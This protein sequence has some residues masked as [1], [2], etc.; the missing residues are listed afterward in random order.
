MASTAVLTVAAGGTVQAFLTFVAPLLNAIVT[1]KAAAAEVAGKEQTI[2]AF[3]AVG[4][5][6]KGALVALFA[7]LAVFGALRALATLLAVIA[8]IKLLNTALTAAGT[9]FGTVMA[10]ITLLTCFAPGAEARLASKAVFTVSVCF[11]QTSLAIAAVAS[12]IRRT[13][14]AHFADFTVFGTSGA[15]VAQR[16]EQIVAE[17]T[18][19]MATG[20]KLIILRTVAAGRAMIAVFKRAFIAHTTVI[21][22]IVI[23]AATAAIAQ[24]AEV[25][26]VKA[27][28]TAVSTVIAGVCRAVD[29]EIA[30]G[31][32]LDT[33][34]ASSAFLADIQIVAALVTFRTVGIFGAF[35]TYSAVF[36]QFIRVI[37]A[38]VATG[39]VVIIVTGSAAFTAAVRAFAA[40][41]VI[42]AAST[43][44]FALHIVIPRIGCGRMHR[45]R[46]DDHSQYDQDTPDPFLHR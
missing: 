14:L 16:A 34:L 45:K 3:L 40:D 32:V 18:Y 10:V 25:F 7:F 1:L 15:P 21:A 39:A 12:I 11:I 6:I 19:L 22:E 37:K 20:T 9:D 29:A 35:L 5:L 27:A 38:L 41:V 13:F 42:A 30:V 8:V 44:I 46:S 33:P 24:V 26:V 17:C 28:F 36:A 43:T 23:S 4:A 2:F 31:T